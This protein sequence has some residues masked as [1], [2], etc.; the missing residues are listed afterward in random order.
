MPRKKGPPDVEKGH[1][2]PGLRRLAA[3]AVYHA[4]PREGLAALQCGA[5]ASER[6]LHMT[7]ELMH[8]AHLKFQALV[9]AQGWDADYLA[10]LDKEHFRKA[11]FKYLP[12]LLSRQPG[13]EAMR[14]TRTPKLTPDE[15]RDA[16]RILATPVKQGDS[17][18]HWRSVRECL[19]TKHPQQARFEAL[20]KKS[21]VGCE[22][23]AD[24]LERECKGMLVYGTADK[25]GKLKPTTLKKRQAAAAVWGHRK[26]WKQLVQ[27]S[28]ARRLGI[29]VTDTSHRGVDK[30][31][32]R[33]L[34]WDWE[35]YTEFSVMMDAA[36]FE[37]AEGG[38]HHAEQV[39]KLKGVH[40]PPELCEPDKPVKQRTKLMAYCVIHAYEGRVAGP[41]LM[42]SGSKEPGFKGTTKHSRGF[43]HWCALSPRPSDQC[44]HV[45]TN[46]ARARYMRAGLHR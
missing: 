23:F 29:A 10:R 13:C 7:P 9:V 12:R 42:Y 41:Y 37:D 4:L 40:Y 30:S 25:A 19:E 8:D 43:P 22:A 36:T 16:A 6:S 5:C 21:G 28:E 31:K 44:Y 27:R 38:A 39:Y 15:L 33:T 35:V 24:R 3:E 20:C 18:R 45:H 26:P 2:P 34:M 46:R 14:Q 32:L 17:W 11:A 1:L